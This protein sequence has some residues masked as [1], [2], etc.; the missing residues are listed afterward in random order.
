MAKVFIANGTYQHQVF[1]YR[2][3]E[4]TTIRRLTIPAKQQ[5][6][7]AEDLDGTALQYVVSQ[8]EGRGGVPVSD[9]NA[10]VGA[11]S[12]VYMIARPFT[13][14]RLDEVAAKDIEVRQ[15]IA[16]DQAEKTSLALFNGIGAAAPDKINST[17]LEVTQMQDTSEEA[18]EG[19]VDYEATV[20]KKAGRRRDTTRR[21]K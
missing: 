3:P 15:E 6:E 2:I 18:K 19:G 1:E 14:E 13:T 12:L 7:L 17:T 10:I 4:Q 9:I 11:Y 16:G 20:S 21:A 5:R 8:L